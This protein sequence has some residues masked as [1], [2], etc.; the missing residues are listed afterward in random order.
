[1]ENSDGTAIPVTVVA[2]AKPTVYA[3]FLLLLTQSRFGSMTWNTKDK[4]QRYF[5]MTPWGLVL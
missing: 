5:S 1:M 2:P 4:Q 3:V